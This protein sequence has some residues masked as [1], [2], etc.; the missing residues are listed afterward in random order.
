MDTTGT[1][2]A[3]V[4]MLLEMTSPLVQDDLLADSAFR[5][6]YGLSSAV[7]LSFAGGEVSVSRSEL[8]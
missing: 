6:T 7:M 3:A 1:S 5:D 8:V 4:S 2:A